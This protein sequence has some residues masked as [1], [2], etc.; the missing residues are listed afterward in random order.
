MGIPAKLVIK[1]LHDLNRE[2][3]TTLI[4]VTQ[5]ELAASTGRIIR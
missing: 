2:S 5:P 1:L 4:P 3:G